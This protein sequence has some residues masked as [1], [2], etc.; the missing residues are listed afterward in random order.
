LSAVRNVFGSIVYE[1]RQD[2]KLYHFTQLFL[3]REMWG[4]D[5]RILNADSLREPDKGLGLTVPAPYIASGYL[6]THFVEAL[7]NFLSVA[8]SQLNLRYPFRVE[9]GLI[10]IKGYSIAVGSN[11]LAGK[12]LREDIQWR[13]EI[14]S[15]KPV[16]EVLGPFFDLIWAACGIKRPPARQDELEKRWSSSPRQ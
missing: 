16:W 13:I 7:E 14:A 10:G 4:V 15:E 2:G 11:Q 5:A 9:A 12:V 3:S 8:K 6:E 1:A